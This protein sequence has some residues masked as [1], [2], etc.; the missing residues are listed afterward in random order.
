MEN[1]YALNINLQKHLDNDCFYSLHVCCYE[2]PALARLQQDALHS[3]TSRVSVGLDRGG[4]CGHR[5]LAPGREPCTS[6]CLWL[7]VHGGVGLGMAGRVLAPIFRPSTPL[8]HFFR[9][10]VIGAGLVAV[11]LLAQSPLLPLHAD[12]APGVVVGAHESLVLVRAARVVIYPIVSVLRLLIGVC[13][14]YLILEGRSVISVIPERAVV[15][16]VG[17]LAH[18]EVLVGG[19]L[20]WWVWLLVGGWVLLLLGVV[21]ETH[22]VRFW[23]AVVVGAGVV[24]RRL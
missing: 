7:R 10:W 9:W 16:A 8:M 24:G 22:A 20:S 23:L 2:L 15:L 18:M 21:L 14:L 6:P 19:L 13:G 3:S 1:S 12:R 11:V 4:H 17:V 5:Q